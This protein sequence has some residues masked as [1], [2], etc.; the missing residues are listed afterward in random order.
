MKR[1]RIEKVVLNIGCGTTL[2][3]ENARTV[4]ERVAGAKAVITKTKRRSTF[5]VPKNKPI[6]CKVTVRKGAEA[7]VKR[8]LESKENRLSPGNFDAYGNFAFGIREYI[9][10]PGMEYDPKL[11][12]VGMD[13]CVTLERPG[14]AVK[15]RRLPVP[16]GKKHR[17]THEEAMQFAKEKFGVQIE[18]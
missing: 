8:L 5:N 12:I 13:V 15:R 6:G 4:I 17:I 18:E 3:I 11:G 16:V 9:D 10:I 2:P 7:F 1:I 14:Y